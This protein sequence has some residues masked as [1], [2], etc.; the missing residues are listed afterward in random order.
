M[1]GKILLIN[2][3]TPDEETRNLLG[4]L[5]MT[6]FEQA[7]LSRENLPRKKRRKFYLIVD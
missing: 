3:R 6:N 1:K 5:L 2:L 7:S 4:S